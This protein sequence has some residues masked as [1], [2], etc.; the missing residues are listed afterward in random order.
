MKSLKEKL[1]QLVQFSERT[2]ASIKWYRKQG[3][4]ILSKMDRDNLSGAS[5]ELEVLKGRLLSRIANFDKD[6]EIGDG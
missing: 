1:S 3:S 5:D 6:K 2:M 4:N